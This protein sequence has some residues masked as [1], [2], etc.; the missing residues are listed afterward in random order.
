MTTPKV[1]EVVTFRLKPGC[2]PADFTQAAQAMTPFLRS[3]GA[4]ISRTL[5]ADESGLWTEFITW[6]SMTAAKEA[7]AAMFAR[8]EAAPFMAMIDQSDMSMRHAEIAVYLPP[9][10]H[11]PD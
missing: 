7:A 8:P 5:S 1:A 3:T 11:A 2:A 4:M 10:D 6:T 9:E